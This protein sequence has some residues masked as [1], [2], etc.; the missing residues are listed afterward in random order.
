MIQKGLSRVRRDFMFV[1]FRNR[2]A[3]ACPEM[4]D[5]ATLIGSFAALLRPADG[6]DKRLR[7]WIT[8]TRRADLPHLHSWTVPV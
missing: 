2:I 5:L 8:D 3:A 4:T 6:H 7:Q 1:R